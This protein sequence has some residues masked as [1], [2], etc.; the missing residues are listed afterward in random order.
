MRS[1]GGGQ[2]SRCDVL[3]LSRRLCRA[4]VGDYLHRMNVSERPR[5]ILLADCDS[6]F[7]RC[8]M[9][10]DPEGAGKTDLLLVGGRP[11][12]R[13]VVTSASYAARAFGAHAGM[14]MSQAIRLCPKA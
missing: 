9:L 3:D 11:D 2:Q 6:Y 12:G 4:A 10:A 7:V 14:P 13:G 1:G 5:R 8:A